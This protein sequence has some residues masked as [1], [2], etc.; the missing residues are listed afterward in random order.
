MI[1]TV[2]NKFAVK[3]A[4]HTSQTELRFVPCA[5]AGC[6][7]GD[8]AR[9]PVWWIIRRS[10]ATAHT[11]SGGLRRLRRYVP[12]GCIACV[13]V[14]IPQHGSSWKNV[15]AALDIVREWV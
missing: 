1:A 10:G 15:H 2:L 4:K 9:K 7:D 13:N 6:V 3:Q 14:L 11:S 5:C 8:V 12:F